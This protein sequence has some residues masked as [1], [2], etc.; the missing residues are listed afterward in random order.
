MPALR[1]FNSLGRELEEFHPLEPGLARI[2]CCGPTVYNDPHIGNLRT[3]L[4]EDLLH[5][6]LKY[7]GYR[8][9]LVMN[10]TDV[11]DKTIRNANA[12]GLSLDAYTAPFIDSFLADL[13]KL[14]VEPATVYP[15]ATEHIAELLALFER[16]VEAGHAYVS[17]GSVF[18]RIASDPDYGRL[19]GFNLDEVQQGE[20]VASDEYGKDDIRDFVLW[21]AAKPSEPAWDSPWGRG[22][23]GWH[24]ECS[25][26]SMKYL[27]ESFD[28]HC[29]GVDLIFPHHENEIAQSEGATGKPFAH[30]WLHSEHLIVDGEKMS[31]SL[32]NQ[33]VL[34]DLLARGISPRVLRYFLISVHYRQKINFTFAG[35]E[36]AAGALR[37]LDELRFRLGSAPEA[38]PP[39][40]EIAAACRELGQGFAAALSD[41][42]NVS[43]ALAALFGLVK[44][45]NVA[46]EAGALG[47]GDRDRVLA[48]LADVD[49]VL[50]VL[51]AGAWPAAQPASGP[52]DEEIE[53]A[54]AARQAA[55]A[56]RNFAEADRL[57]DE[58]LAQGV[59]LEDTPQ[60]TRWKRR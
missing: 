16:L 31:K 42:L 52:G 50:A 11:D 23:P 6:S 47:E 45:V 2:Y 46:I 10:I 58:L 37:R 59:V 27:G 3:F 14:H 1:F 7:L 8:V 32:G 55:R 54:I 60:G 25:A 13:G 12:A 17:E 35:L 18:F 53:Q 28:L 34:A 26:M 29:G 19:S 41:D 9:V 48:A 56:A 39:R 40:P 36:A 22:R 51:D 38:G 4:F 30:T 21:K 20:R 33:Y 43:Q 24:I 5:R 57:R 44:E 15:R 49:R